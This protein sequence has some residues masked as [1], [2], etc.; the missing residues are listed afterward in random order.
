MC[1][2]PSS[3][4]IEAATTRLPSQFYWVIILDGMTSRQCHAS[5]GRVSLLCPKVD[6]KTPMTFQA[7]KKTESAKGK[8]YTSEEC[9]WWFGIL[10]WLMTTK[11]GT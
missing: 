11:S 2:R 5:G 7:L 8:S 9:S 6:H 10:M 3:P 4:Q 1:Q